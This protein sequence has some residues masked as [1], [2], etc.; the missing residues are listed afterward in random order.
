M[1]LAG[2][3]LL[4][5]R[6]GSEDCP[7]GRPCVLQPKLHRHTFQGRVVLNVETAECRGQK[8]TPPPPQTETWKQLRLFFFFNIII[9]T[10]YLPAG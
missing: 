10:L 6:G 1:S 5:K 2:Q 9:L 4:C 7:A 3:Q 8:E